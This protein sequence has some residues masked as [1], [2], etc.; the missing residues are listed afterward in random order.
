MALRDPGIKNKRKKKC[1]LIPK[2]GI[3]LGW[4]VRVLVNVFEPKA[5]LMQ[6]KPK[7][8]TEVENRSETLTDGATEA[9]SPN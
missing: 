1:H 4:K 3:E 7:L 2:P 9:N 8:S 5:I 6:V